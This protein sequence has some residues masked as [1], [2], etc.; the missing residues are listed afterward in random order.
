[1]ENI[2]KHC[3]DIFIDKFKSYPS[4][5]ELNPNKTKDSI[6]KFLSKSELVWVNELISD[7]GKKH[8]LEKFVVYDSTGIMIYINEELTLFILT[9]IDRYEVADFSIQTLKRL[10]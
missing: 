7:E 9:T 3:I 10:K 5:I 1:M 6:N 4:V 2:P 8:T